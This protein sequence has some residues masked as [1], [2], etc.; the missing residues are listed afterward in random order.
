MQEQIDDD[1]EDGGDPYGAMDAPPLPD[2]RM[3]MIPGVPPRV[4]V[5][6]GVI[7]ACNDLQQPRVITASG[8]SGEPKVKIIR[9]PLHYA[10][11]S[12]FRVAC[13]VLSSYLIGKKANQV[14]VEELAGMKFSDEPDNFEET[15]EEG[16]QE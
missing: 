2:S 3:R 4:L 15:D 6:M 11:E 10:Q 12:T 14:K 5:A 13:Y 7:D 8:I 16:Q 9:T 1:F